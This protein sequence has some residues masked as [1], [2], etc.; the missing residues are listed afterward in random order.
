MALQAAVLIVAALWLCTYFVAFR[1][2]GEAQVWAHRALIALTLLG[3]SVTVALKC[4]N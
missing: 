4:T 1:L 2:S 3:L